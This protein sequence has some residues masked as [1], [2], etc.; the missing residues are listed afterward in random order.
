[1]ARGKANTN[2]NAEVHVEDT[3]HLQTTGWG[4]SERRCREV[5]V[6]GRRVTVA[7]D[8]ASVGVCTPPGVGGTWLSVFGNGL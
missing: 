7:S 8:T 4:N 2:E 6:A 5:W 1:M 3:D